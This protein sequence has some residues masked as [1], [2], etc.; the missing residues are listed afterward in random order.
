MRNLA[1]TWS[2]SEKHSWGLAGLHIAAHMA[3]LRRS[4]LFAEKPDLESTVLPG[5]LNISNALRYY[6][7]IMGLHRQNQ[8]TPVFFGDCDVVHA[9]GNGLRQGKDFSWLQGPKKFA[10]AVFRDT[11]LDQEAIARAADYDR[12]I[13]HSTYNR[14]ILAGKG[15]TNVSLVLHGGNGEMAPVSGPAPGVF[16]QRFAIFSGGKLEFAKGQ[17]IVLAA[18][19]RFHERHRDALLVTAWHNP[20]PQQAVGIAVS[21]HTPTVP[22]TNHDGHLDIVSWAAENGVAPGD[23]VDLGPISRTKLLSFLRSCSAAV[24]PSRCEGA[25]NLSAVDAMACGVPTILSANTGHLDIIHPDRCL[26]LDRQDPVFDLDGGRIG[27]GESSVDEVV[28]RLEEIYA[29]RGPAR[30]HAERAAAFF[31]QE[32]TW[33]RFAREFVQALQA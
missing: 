21:R 31:H 32:R 12:I 26:T 24:F 2:L 14:D 11:N 10:C 6:D 19:R 16:G 8:G 22:R 28:E 5:N 23:L 7:V 3:E 1:I 29:N 18:F 13:V 25:T 30:Q 9:L 33:D 27:W 17:D 15:A 20:W 4:L